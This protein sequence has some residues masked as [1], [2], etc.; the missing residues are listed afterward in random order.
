M[1]RGLEVVGISR[2]VR[3]E[4]YLADVSLTLDEGSLTVV[5]GR[6]RAGKTSL[7]RV[8]AGLDRPDAG[9]LR[10][11]D[12]DVT[13]AAVRTRDVAMVYQQFVNY[14][15]L[16]VY[17]N[18]ASPLRLARR[19]DAAAID[20]RVRETASL[21]RIDGYLQRLPAELSGGQ[22]QRTAIAR[23]LA[24]DA[25]LLLLDEPLA[26]LDF[27]LREELRS[28]L[29]ALFRTR[30]SVV[31]YATAEPSEALLMGGSTVVIDEGRVLQAGPALDVYRAPVSARVGQLASDP[32]MNL[33]DV[34]VDAE[35]EV[36]LSAGLGFRPATRMAPGRYR[37]GVRAH[38]VRL[39]QQSARDLRIAARVRAQEVSGSETLL[40]AQVTSGSAPHALSALVPGVH[41]QALGD[42]IALF[43]DPAR[44]FLFDAAGA[45]CARQAEG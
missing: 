42:E 26:N 31:V 13:G 16:T 36:R 14:P 39:A 2:F 3:G 12:R 9:R 45:L 30:K 33:L 38:D 41:R 21:L 29:R 7:L 37:L 1:N 11:H 17:E 5:L 34:E 4:T 6:T 19:L 8:I 23:A 35:G 18:I 22:Q 40:R 32:E 24:K 44:T 27:K 43:V 10:W 20:R 15:S 25:G 28:E